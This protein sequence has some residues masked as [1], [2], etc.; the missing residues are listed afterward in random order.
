MACSHAGEFFFPLLP[1]GVWADELPGGDSPAAY[2]YTAQLLALARCTPLTARELP[3]SLRE[4]ITP[5]HWPAWEVALRG[6]PDREFAGLIVSGIRQGFRVGFD[7][8]RFDQ[9]RPNRRNLGAAYDH[10]EVVSDYLEDERTHRRI[11][12]P[13]VPSPAI[14]VHTSSFGVIP[15]RHQ[16]N[17][18]SLIVDL[19]SPKGG[20]VNDGVDRSL[21]SFDYI[22]VTDI[23]DVVLGLGRG[24]LLAKSDIRHAY[25]QVPVHPD[26]RLLLGMRWQG[27]VFCDAALPFGLR[28][29]PIIF[30]AVADALEW[31][32]K[33]RGASHVFHY[34]DDF[35]FV[36]PPNSPKCQQELQ[37]FQNICG[38]LGVIIAED[39][40]EGPA[41]CLTVLGI[42]IDTGAMELRLYTGRQARAA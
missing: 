22:A 24:A 19:S 12:G 39:K 23:A 29:A 26:D 40:T 36:G 13:L 30:S 28:S 11:V 4:I 8:H 31:V 42:E 6:H 3:V 37:L 34:M 32:I 20:S 17:K 7:Y 35:V 15:K 27:L 21:C 5:L 18:W 10:P 41:T 38:D 14:P 33:V 25:R 2:R 16:A 1:A 9:L